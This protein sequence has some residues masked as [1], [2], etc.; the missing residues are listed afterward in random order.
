MK[1]SAQQVNRN[2]NEF[3]YA[4]LSDGMNISKHKNLVRILQK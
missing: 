1:K 3:F 2:S 4:A